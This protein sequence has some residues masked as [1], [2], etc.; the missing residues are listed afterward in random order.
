[1]PERH[2]RDD[3]R[4]STWRCTRMTRAASSPT[5]PRSWRGCKRT[6]TCDAQGIGLVDVVYTHVHQSSHVTRLEDSYEAR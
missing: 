5:I 3:T 4:P 6:P 2:D 1:M